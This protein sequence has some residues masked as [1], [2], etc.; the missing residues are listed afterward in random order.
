MSFLSSRRLWSMLPLSATR[1]AAAVPMVLVMLSLRRVSGLLDLP[2]RLAGSHVVQRN[3]PRL[4]CVSA[5][6]A[7]DL[8]KHTIH[9]FTKNMSHWSVQ[10]L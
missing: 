3:H 8:V 7:V 4:L 10:M 9:V 5:S 1:T 2:G 6:M